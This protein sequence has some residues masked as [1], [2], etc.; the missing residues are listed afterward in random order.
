MASRKDLERIRSLPPEER[1][2]EVRRLSELY[3]RSF[4][5]G[6]PYQIARRFERM[7]KAKDEANARILAALARARALESEKGDDDDVSPT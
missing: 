3:E 7:R 4:F 6:T 2:K 1:R 5:K